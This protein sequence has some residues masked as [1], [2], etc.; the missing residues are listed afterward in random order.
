MAGTGKKWAIGCGI[1][2][3]AFLLIIGLLVGGG[4]FAGKRIQERAET[5]ESS[6]EAVKVEFG[7][8]TDFTPPA[9]GFVGPD[10]MEAFF[11]A[12]EA[13]APLRADLDRTLIT[14]DGDANFLEKARAG[15][16]LIP[17]L[18][19]FIEDRNHALTEAGM[20]LG[21]YQYV[22]TLLAYALCEKDLADGPKFTLVSNEDENDG[23]GWNFN[24]GD[25][26]EEDV[27]ERRIRDLRRMI[28]DFQVR[29]MENQLKAVDGEF[30]DGSSMDLGGL[31]RESWRSQ[32]EAEL[33]SLRE[34]RLKLMWE[35]GLPDHLAASLEP[36]RTRFEESYDPMTS[37]LEMGLV[38]HD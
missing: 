20:G 37:V 11:A 13:M 2:C 23:D 32:L 21:E 30:V 3:G 18:M 15:F 9:G 22:Y 33:G 5:M 26:D 28:N 38:D 12:R 4:I 29:V 35:D 19:D 36:Y 27:R 8:S 34:E 1:G 25:E 6:F 17:E 31:D 10:R 24:T 7:A 16:K 14:L